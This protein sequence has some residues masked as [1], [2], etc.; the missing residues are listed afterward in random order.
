MSFNH[1]SD[2]QTVRRYSYQDE[3]GKP[4]KLLEAWRTVNPKEKTARIT[5]GE[6]QA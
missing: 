4:K 6:S 1:F 3:K 5:G 2:N